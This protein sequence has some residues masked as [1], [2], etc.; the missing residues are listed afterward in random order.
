MAKV[1]GRPYRHT[2]GKVL[3]VPEEIKNYVMNRLSE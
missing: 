2:D 1:Y 3:Q